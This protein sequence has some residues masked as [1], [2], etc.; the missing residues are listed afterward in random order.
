M[1]ESLSRRRFLQ[2]SAAGLVALGG[3]GADPAKSRYKI[4]AC[5]WMLLK[6]Q[7]PSAIELA[8]QCGLDGVE[9]DMG[10]LGTRTELDNRLRTPEDRQ[11]YQDAGKKFG[12]EICSLALSALYGHS[13][14]DHPSADAITDEWIETLHKM[15]VKVGFLPIGFQC[16]LVTNDA[17]RTKVVARLKRAA[18]AA[19]K[20][21]VVLGLETGLDA[22]GHRKLLD[23]VGSPAVQVYYNL[24]DRLEVGADIYGELRQL[25]RDRVCQIHCKEGN[26]HLGQGK[27]DFKKVKAALDD[28]NWSG[29]LVI[30]RSRLPNKSVLE[31]FSANARY[32]K[33]IF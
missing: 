16:D 11:Q 18:P 7:K 5:D 20:A 29:W 9:V 32:L 1:N 21:G 13:Y 15:T 33:S 4:A 8:K 30:E 22:D 25:G 2:S 26:V 12:V 3:V 19:E 14:A 28:I 27:I 10:K 24:G 23:E 31:N 6:R 17:A